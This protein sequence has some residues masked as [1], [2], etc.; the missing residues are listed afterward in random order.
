MPVPTN[1]PHDAL[2]KSIFSQPDEV[3]AELQHV[4]S[5]E[6]V[7]AI[8]WSTLTLEPGSFVDPELSHHHT[9][10]LFSARAS[11]ERVLVYLLF[12]HQ[13]TPDVHMPLRLLD[14]MVQIWSLHAK[15]DPSD[16]LPLIIPALL[17]QVPG[18]WRGPTRFSA[19]FDRG[20]QRLGG[21]VIPD[22]SFAVDDLHHA[23]DDDLVARGLSAQATLALWAMRDARDRAT[24]LAR[25]TRWAGLL[26]DLA[27]SPNGEDALGL[28]LRYIAAVSGDLQ[29]ADFRATLAGKA[30][31][32]EAIAMTI[33]EI[34][35]A[36]V[37]AAGRAEG[38]AAGRAEGEAQGVRK[39]ILAVLEA[40]G[41]H[42]PRQTRARLQACAD[43]ETLDRL[44]VTAASIDRVEALF[45]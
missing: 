37:R 32:A 38:R 29:L 6:L 25:L 20:A 30:P 43:I 10:L 34:L 42:V 18:G 40:R 45:D 13:S 22:F 26:E 12:E 27:R 4:L 16:P 8:D 39:S 41:L 44:L 23:S 1:T 14:Y 9:D 28:L 36:K 11:G 3:A 17:A 5:D 31:T 15:N 2:F 21:A 33:A 7:A 24:L 35:E 19:M